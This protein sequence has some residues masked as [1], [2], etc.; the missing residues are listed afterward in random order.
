MKFIKTPRQLATIL[1]LSFLVPVVLIILV[2]KAVMSTRAPD[3]AVLAPE[4]VAARIK[5]VADV[6][7]Q[8]GESAA[9][10][11]AQTGEEVYKSACAACHQ[12]G[13]ANAPKFG[14][15][16]AWAGHIAEGLDAMV[17][18]AISGI[19][20]MPPRGGNPNLSDLEIARAVIYMANAAGASFPEPAAPAA[21][22]K[23]AAVSAARGAV[24]RERSGEQIVQ[25]TC[26]TCHLTGEGGAPK[27]GDKAAWS[28]R[29]ARGLEAVTLSAIR[30]HGGMPARGGLADLTDPE[31]RKAILYMF[32]SGGGKIVPA[33]SAPALPAPPASAGGAASKGDGKAVYDKACIACHQ[34]GVAGAPKFGD[35][36][37]WA[38]RIKQGI[39]TLYTSSIKG[40]GAMPPKGGQVALSDADIKAAVDYMVAAAK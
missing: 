18:V 16:R 17:K 35:K 33:A 39:E 10:S 31:V 37:V 24:E 36:A 25:G 7:V 9:A 38:T 21:E 3:P 14:D 12:T 13:V 11:G 15:K 30:G 20:G 4:A 26:G 23:P 19:R 6:A 28:K 34:A 29:I 5:P 2:T 8:A 22:A 32:E 40:K 27:I 1:F